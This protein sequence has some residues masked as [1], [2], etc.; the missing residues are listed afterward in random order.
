MKIIEYDAFQKELVRVLWSEASGSAVYEHMLATRWS[1]SF[2][3][4]A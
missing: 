4:S 2:I 3:N 1:L